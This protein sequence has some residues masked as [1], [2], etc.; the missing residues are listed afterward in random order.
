L[1]SRFCEDRYGG[2]A[3][4]TEE[5]NSVTSGLL[6]GQH[7]GVLRTEALGMRLEQCKRTNSDEKWQQV[8]LLSIAHVA[9]MSLMDE[10][11]GL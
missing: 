10:A 9:V 8:T 11:A 3:L 6:A 5:I 4:L 2:V 7:R 1:F